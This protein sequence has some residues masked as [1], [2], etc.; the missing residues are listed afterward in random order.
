MPDDFAPATIRDPASLRAVLGEPTA[1]VRNKEM[2]LLDAHC[3]RFIELS[4]M[5]F[6]GSAGADGKGDVTPRGDPP[7]FVTILD[8][9]TLLIPERV[10]NR[11]GDTLNNVLAHP[12]V[13]MIFMIPGVDETLR[14]N[15]RASIVD[16]PALLAP[17]ALNGKTPKLALRIDITDAFIHCG[18]A[19]KRARLWDPKSAIDRTSFASMAQ[20]AHDQRRRDTSVAELESF[21]AEFY[22]TLY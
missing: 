15:G 7:G 6:I 11:R 12:N 22:A 14:V 5:V 2:P 10:G 20:M 3:R 9:R 13:G 21:F 8:D 19:L 1:T 18:R 16:D 17:M 4:P